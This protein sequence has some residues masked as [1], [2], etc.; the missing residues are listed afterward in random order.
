VK[1]AVILTNYN[2]PERAD[3]LHDAVVNRSIKYET[4]FILVD[5]GSDLKEPSKYTTVRLNENQQVTGGW[6]AGLKWCAGKYDYYV[7]TI[8]SSELEQEGNDLIA[9]M[10]DWLH[11]TKNAVGV[12]PA[13]TL[14]STTSWG[15][16]YTRGG[17]A[18]RQTWMLDNLFAMYDARWFDSI[19]WFDKEMIYGWGVDLETSFLA[20]Y[21]YKSLWVDERC[22]V[23]KVTDIGY[24][25]NRMNMAAEDRRRLAG[26]NMR[27]KLYQKYGKNY[28]EMMTVANVRPEWK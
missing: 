17:D 7:F 5:N 22:R 6:L 20:R 3:A 21:Q 12:H 16:L 23:K 9:L 27:A 1:I 8:T 24:A 18:P 26:D 19:G 14:D 25:M 11:E 10:A 2:M 13:L 15:H 4:D 28:W